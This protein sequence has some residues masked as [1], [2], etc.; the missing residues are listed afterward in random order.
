MIGA[1]TWWMRL[2]LGHTNLLKN[3]TKI[4]AIKQ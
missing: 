4:D 1:P 2:I 3:V